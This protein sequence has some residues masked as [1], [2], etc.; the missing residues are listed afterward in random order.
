M[1]RKKY[2]AGGMA[3]KGAEMSAAGRARRPDGA[4]AT[5]HAMASQKSAAGLARKPEGAGR[6]PYAKG[7]AVSPR[8]AMAMKNV[9]G[10]SSCHK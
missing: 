3:G 1:K 5:G 6:V 7:G 2:M 9:K 4:G 8:K 10:K